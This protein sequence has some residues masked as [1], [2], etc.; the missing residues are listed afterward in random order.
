MTDFFFVVV[1]KDAK[2]KK[3]KTNTHEDASGRTGHSGCF[4]MDYVQYYMA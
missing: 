3:F 1:P 4:A 2:W